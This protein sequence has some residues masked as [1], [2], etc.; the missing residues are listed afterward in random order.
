MA[1]ERPEG[2]VVSMTG[3]MISNEPRI[4]EFMSRMKIPALYT[5]PRPARMGG[6][7]SFSA[8]FGSIMDRA[9]WIV[10]K[11]LK[12]AKPNDIPVEEPSRFKLSINMRTARSM[13]FT[14][15]RSFMMR[16]DEVF[17]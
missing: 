9:A 2:A 15:P 16:V 4:I 17:E 10:D 7:I 3:A 1:R 14:F 6:L 8:D 12:G 11:I 13:G 5:T